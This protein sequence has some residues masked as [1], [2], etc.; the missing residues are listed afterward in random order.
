MVV[1]LGPVAHPPHHYLCVPS[2]GTSQHLFLSSDALLVPLPPGWVMQV[3]KS[4]VP[5]C[6]SRGAEKLRRP[7][8]VGSGCLSELWPLPLLSQ[9]PSACQGP[10][11]GACTAVRQKAGCSSGAGQG[12]I[13]KPQ[14]PHLRAEKGTRATTMTEE[15]GG[16]SGGGGCYLQPGPFDAPVELVIFTA[17]APEAVGHPIA[18]TQKQATSLVPSSQGHS[19]VSYH[20]GV[21]QG[22]L[23]LLVPWR[24]EW[25]PRSHSR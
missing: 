9:G 20:V 21:G 12:A 5:S 16:L 2:Q 18:L 4:L 23:L 1:R 22:P 3:V 10:Q 25:T 13:S 7:K 15:V 11:A 6:D 24:F 14:E 8:E 19:P 17:P